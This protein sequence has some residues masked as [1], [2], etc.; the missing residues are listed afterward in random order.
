MCNNEKVLIGL[1]KLQAKQQR[2]HII[3]KYGRYNFFTLSLYKMH[4]WFKFK[5]YSI[6]SA[7]KR[8]YFKLNGYQEL[9]CEITQCNEC[10]SRNSMWRAGCHC[11]HEASVKHGW[12]LANDNFLSK[13][14]FKTSGKTYFIWV[15]NDKFQIID[16]KNSN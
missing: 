15:Q 13:E 4:I 8:G 2:N 16:A 14:E 9:I 7:F 5:R 1:D 3:N 11:Y 10:N 12:L 6:V